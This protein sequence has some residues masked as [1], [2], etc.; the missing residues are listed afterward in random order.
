MVIAHPERNKSVVRRLTRELFNAG[1]D[2]DVARTLLASDF[3]D[4]TSPPS[5]DTDRQAYIRRA[6]ELRATVTG[7]RTESEELVG[8]GDVVF[9]RF[10]RTFRQAGRRVEEVG[11]AQYRLRHG[12]IVEAW[13]QSQTA[14]VPAGT[15]DLTPRELRVALLVAEGWSNPEVATELSL[16]RKTI[17]AHLSAIYRKLGLRSRLELTRALAPHLERLAPAA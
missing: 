10:R 2:A 7:L 8:E 15:N 16:S 17:E 5:P 1:G 6:L 14:L 11:F 12:R 3:T 9:E 13:G 4:R